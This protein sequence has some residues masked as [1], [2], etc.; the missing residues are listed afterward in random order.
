MEFCKSLL[1]SANENAVFGRLERFG[2]VIV[3]YRRKYQYFE[4]GALQARRAIESIRECPAFSLAGASSLYFHRRLKMNFLTFTVVKRGLFVAPVIKQYPD[5]WKRTTMKLYAFAFAC[6]L[7]LPAMAVAD[8]FQPLVYEGSEG[9]GH[10]KHVV[11]IANDHEYRSEQTCPLVAKLLAKHLGFKCTVVFGLNEDGE[12]KGGARNTPGMEA[13]ADADLVFFFT[14][15]M[16]LPDQQAD[17]LVEYFERGGPVVGVRTSTHCFNGQKGKWAKLNY[18]YK[19]GDYHGGLGEQVFGNT[20]EKSAGQ[21]HYGRN[22]VMGCR[23][24]PMADAVDHAIMAGVKQIHAYSGAYKSHP[25]ADSTPLLEVQ[26]LNTFGPS[27]DIHKEL[28]KVCAGWTREQ[29]VAPSG[30]KKDARVVYTSFG[31][32]EDLLSEDGRRFLVNACL[33]AVGMEKQIKPDLD[34]SIV[35]QYKPSPYTNGGFY[36]TGVKPA[37]LAGLDSAI[38]PATAEMAGMADKNYVKKR[39]SILANRPYWKAELEKRYPTILG[40]E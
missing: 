10:G 32:S 29:Y 19:G 33:W 23:I 39:E 7:I 38:M 27:D 11:L 15:F 26:V 5:R 24:T 28:P 3:V 25:P 13:L 37:D 12:I 31:A 21:S 22:H 30:E 9:I 4:I 18:N 2:C 16:N 14:R 34:V 17:L 20:W 36:F 40:D 8:E 35:G 1:S 6:L